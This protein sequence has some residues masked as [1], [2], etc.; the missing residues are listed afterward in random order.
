M[1]RQRHIRRTS[2]S[3][4]QLPRSATQLICGYAQSTNSRQIMSRKAISRS[5]QTKRI[6]IRASPNYSSLV[7]IVIRMRRGQ[8][9]SDLSTRRF[10]IA[11]SSRVRGR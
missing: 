5:L 11:A 1:G 10:T 7:F 3:V 4:G 2:P 9:F 8:E 6:N